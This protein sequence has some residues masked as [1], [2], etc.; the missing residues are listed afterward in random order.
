[1]FVSPACAA[2]KTSH[3]I[4]SLRVNLLSWIYRL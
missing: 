3:Q 2:I 4:V 1:L